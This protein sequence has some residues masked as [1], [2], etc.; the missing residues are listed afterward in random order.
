MGICYQCKIRCFKVKDL[1]KVNLE[2]LEYCGENREA[3]LAQYYKESKLNIKKVLAVYNHE[4]SAKGGYRIIRLPIPIGTNVI[5]FGNDACD[6]YDMTNHYEIT[7]YDEEMAVIGSE[8]KTAK[9]ERNNFM[10]LVPENTRSI[11]YEIN[12]SSWQYQRYDRYHDFQLTMFCNFCHPEFDPY[13]VSE[14]CDVEQIID[15]SCKEI[16]N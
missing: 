7:F 14:I 13:E 2:V 3:K 10:L 15:Q 6:C 16:R 8:H 11:D 5:A 9:F 1:T 4:P 12:E